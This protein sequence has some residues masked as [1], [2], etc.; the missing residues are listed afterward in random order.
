MK[1]VDILAS[2]DAFWLAFRNAAAKNGHLH[3]PANATYVFLR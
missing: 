2:Y 3:S 1:K